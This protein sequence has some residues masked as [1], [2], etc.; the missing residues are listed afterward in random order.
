[1]AREI[2]FG[3]RMMG[4]GHPAYVIAEVGINHN[5]DLDIAK[6]IIDAAAHAGA[7]AAAQDRILVERQVD[8]Q[9]S[10]SGGCWEGHFSYGSRGATI[11][12]NQ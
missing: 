3:K 9:D 2:K 12:S 6:K 4:D 8:I 11:T 1:M 10:I 5:G 7:D